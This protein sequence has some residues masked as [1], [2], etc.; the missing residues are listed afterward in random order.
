[1]NQRTAFLDILK[2]LVQPC[3]GGWR[4]SSF[5][6]LQRELEERGKGDLV[7]RCAGGTG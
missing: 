1:M 2:S 6:V 3:G 4:H 7:R 5:R